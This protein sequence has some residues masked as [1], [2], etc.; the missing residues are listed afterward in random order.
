M[1]GPSSIPT[2]D[3]VRAMDGRLI[4]LSRLE[5]RLRLPYR[6]CRGGWTLQVCTIA[7]E[8]TSVSVTKVPRIEYKGWRVPRT[9]VSQLQ[10]VYHGE[11]SCWSKLMQSLI[12]IPWHPGAL[13]IRGPYTVQTVTPAYMHRPSMVAT[14]SERRLC[15]T[16]MLFYPCR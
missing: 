10:A 7:Q 5:L 12:Q 2:E 9:E 13:R 16:I 6:N 1:N 14:P 4:T 8:W 3:H 11:A 15:T